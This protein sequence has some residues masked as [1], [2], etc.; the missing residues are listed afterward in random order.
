MIPSAPVG[1]K[2]RIQYDGTSAGKY[3]K[4]QHKECKIIVGM[5]T[6]RASIEAARRKA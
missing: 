4:L 1:K 5:A 2:D 3:M 6:L